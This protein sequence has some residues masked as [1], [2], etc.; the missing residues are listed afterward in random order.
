MGSQ[1]CKQLYLKGYEIDAIVNSGSNVSA[2]FLDDI[3][4][5]HIDQ[6]HNLPS[7]SDAYLIAVSDDQYENVIATFPYKDKLMHTSGSFESVKF[8]KITKRWCCLY[9]F[10]LFPKQKT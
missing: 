2:K 8:E 10:K 7:E 5:I 9:H 4:S 1:L 6:I 3:N